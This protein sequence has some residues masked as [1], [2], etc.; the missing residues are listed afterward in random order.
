TGERFSKCPECGKSFSDSSN[1]T[2]HQRRHQ[3]GKPC[4]C[5]DCG[6]SFAHCSN[7]IPHQRTHVG[8]R[9]GDL[10]T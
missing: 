2:K 10:A 8:K 5:P 1:F 9:A 4:E 7:I 6:K 3:R